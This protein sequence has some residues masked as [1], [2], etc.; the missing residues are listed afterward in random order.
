MFEKKVAASM[1]ANG[2]GKKNKMHRS[3]GKVKDR[4]WILR[5]KD[6]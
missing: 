6:R 5:K 1:G 2:I 3:N 4:N